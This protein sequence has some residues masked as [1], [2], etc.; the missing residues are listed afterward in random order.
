[1]ATAESSVLVDTHAFLWMTV[2]PE[3]L[4]SVARARIEDPASRVLL[5]LAS[6]W[7]I[8]IKESLGKLE[9]PAPVGSFVEEQLALTRTAILPISFGHAVRVAELPWHH[10]DPFD[11]LL[12]AQA[13]VDRIPLLS[14]DVSLDP[15]GVER[16]W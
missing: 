1:M 7:E 5:S 16:L 10:R 9:L 6:V 14:T 4:G 11:R 2:E 8:A 12:V 13:L 3:R 15:Y